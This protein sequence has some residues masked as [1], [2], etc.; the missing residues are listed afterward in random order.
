MSDTIDTLVRRRTAFTS[1]ADLLNSV[2]T[3][4]YVPSLAPTPDKRESAEREAI[5]IAVEKQGGRVWR[6]SRPRTMPQ[7]AP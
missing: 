2:R 1:L 4:G 6:G 3:R 5:A 7:D